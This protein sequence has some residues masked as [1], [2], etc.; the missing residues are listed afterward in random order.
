MIL[1]AANAAHVARQRIAIP[2][3]EGAF[4]QGASSRDVRP[5]SRQF[6]R[7][8]IGAYFWRQDGAV[9]PAQAFDTLQSL[10]MVGHET[11]TI[12]LD[13]RVPHG[14][15]AEDAIVLTARERRRYL[16]VDE[17]FSLPRLS[18]QILTCASC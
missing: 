1:T 11:A 17:D 14:Y 9:M 10:V 3:Q 8:K 18:R 6:L 12:A 13:N 5:K 16:N 4:F 15:I 7:R 2:T